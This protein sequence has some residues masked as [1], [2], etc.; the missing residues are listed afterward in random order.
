MNLLKLMDLR[1]NH[2]MNFDK[3]KGKIYVISLKNLKIK[4]DKFKCKVCKIF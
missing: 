4:L 1:K 3:F 2:S